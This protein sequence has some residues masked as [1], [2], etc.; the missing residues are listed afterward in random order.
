MSYRIGIDLDGILADF[1]KY[2]TELIRS[3]LRDTELPVHTHADLPGYDLQAHYPDLRGRIKEARN[4]FHQIPNVW[5]YMPSLL[6]VTQWERLGAQM[7]GRWEFYFITARQSARRGDSVERQ[8]AGWLSEHLLGAMPFG[9][10]VGPIRV[11]SCP[12][13]EHVPQK[14]EVCRDLGILVMIDEHPDAVKA[15]VDGGVQCL[16]QVYP[17]NEHI[18]TKGVWRAKDFDTILDFLEMA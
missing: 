9:M 4:V 8:T 14:P 3:T 16:M 18:D 5:A 11:H 7:R 13:D 6:S 17:Y 12:Y 15:L 10:D 2:W 1:A